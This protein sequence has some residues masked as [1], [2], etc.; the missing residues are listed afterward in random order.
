MNSST[1]T[2]QLTREQLRFA[3]ADERF[4]RHRIAEQRHGDWCDGCNPTNEELRREAFAAFI[5]AQ[6]EEALAEDIERLGDA[7][8][9]ETPAD[10]DARAAEAQ[11]EI[12]G[13]N[14]E[15]RA[16]LRQLVTERRDALAQVARY[17]TENELL[18]RPITDA[19]DE[20]VLQLF[21]DAAKEA[22]RQGYCSTYEQIA[23]AVGIP[24]RDRL[25]ELGYLV[26]RYNVDV[27]V[28]VRATVTVEAS[29]DDEAISTVDDFDDDELR[30]A[31]R[32]GSGLD[33][34]SIDSHDAQAA[35]LQ[36]D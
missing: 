13:A 11:A 12:L 36:E 17:Q 4:T 16:K 25:R 14:A 2:T 30:R 23:S 15:Q 33:V 21:A 27:L 9:A 3:L 31:L 19:E 18:R 24:G 20:R 8:A 28:T 10:R 22:D 6:H 29:S 5:D 7:L 1:I 34:Y 26:G 32:D 35:E